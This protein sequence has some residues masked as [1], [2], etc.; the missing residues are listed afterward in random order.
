M[1]VIG[2]ENDFIVDLEGV[3]ETA[4]FLGVSPVFIP[5]LY[6]DVMLGPKWIKS[7]EIIAQWVRQI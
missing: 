1:L 3:K 6:H 2:A 4:R 5:D 7:A